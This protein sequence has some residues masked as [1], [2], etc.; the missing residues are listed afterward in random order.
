MHHATLVGQHASAPWQTTP[1]LAFTPS[2][3]R[4]APGNWQ[5]GALKTRGTSWRSSRPRL[6]IRNVSSSVYGKSRVRVGKFPR[7]VSTLVVLKRRR[8]TIWLLIQTMKRTIACIWVFSNLCPYVWKGLW[9]RGQGLRSCSRMESKG[10]RLLGRPCTL[11]LSTGRG[12]GEWLKA[13][14]S[15][16]SFILWMLF[17]YL[18]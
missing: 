8:M 9:M 2:V 10:A 12:R 18:G 5:S 14:I 11:S 7:S 3:A 16:I 6:V 1:A 17:F 4:Q 15:F 13:R